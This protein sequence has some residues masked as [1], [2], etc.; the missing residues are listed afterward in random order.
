MSAL[1]V[2]GLRV[3]HAVFECSF[4]T[5]S[6]T[7]HRNSTDK[8]NKEERNEVLHIDTTLCLCRLL[9]HGQVRQRPPR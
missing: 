4:G 9:D 8:R 1:G 6:Q 3:I 7:S 2:P 5:C